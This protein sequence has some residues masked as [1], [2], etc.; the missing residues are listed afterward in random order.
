MNQI[1]DLINNNSL[2]ILIIIIII[3]VVIVLLVYIQIKDINLN[4][5][6]PPPKLI[7]EVT[8]EAFVD[9]NLNLKLQPSE[10]FCEVYL[11]KSSDLEGECNMLTESNCAETNCCVLTTNSK[12]NR[13]CVAG[14]INGPTY[15]TDKDGNLL[16]IDSYYFQGHKI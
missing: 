3:I 15:K 1:E 6:K 4:P 16:T 8:V 2:N 5:S 12:G 11:G 7:Q 14:S 9:N 13:K 10:S